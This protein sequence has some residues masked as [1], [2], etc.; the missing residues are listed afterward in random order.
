MVSVSDYAKIPAIVQPRVSPDTGRVAYFSDQSG[1]HE[2]YITTISGETTRLT[3][4][5]PPQNPFSPLIWHPNG[6]RIYLPVGGEDGNKDTVNVGVASLDGSVQTLFTVPRRTILW[7]VAPNGRFLWYFRE[8]DDEEDFNLIR[9]D[10]E[11]GS[12]EE[13]Q[14]NRFVHRGGGVAPTGDRIAFND[15][16]RDEPYGEVFLAASDG[17]DRHPLHINGGDRAFVLGWGPDGNRLLVSS[18]FDDGDLGIHDLREETTEWIRG[19]EGRT[20]GATFLPDGDCVF[21]IRGGEAFVYDCENGEW[22]NLDVNGSVR[23]PPTIQ[24]GSLF[25]SEGVL[26]IRSN[27]TSPGELLRYD[28]R[29]NEITTLVDT[30][31]DELSRSDMEP[32][33]ERTYQ[34]D[35]GEDARVLLY[36]PEMA[37]PAPAVAIVYGGTQQ[38][39][40]RFDALTQL[41]VAE[42]YVVCKPAMTASPYSERE[43]ADFAAAGRWLAEQES[44]DSD[45]I[46]VYGHSHG[47]YNAYSQAVCYS[48]VWNAAIA[49]N[50]MTDLVALADEDDAQWNLRDNM[51]DS[52]DSVETWRNLSPINDADALSIPLLI[53]HGTNDPIV[54]VS[55]ARRFRTA[56]D[57]AGKENYEYHELTGGHGGG[58]DAQQKTEAY[59]QIVEFLH[60][61]L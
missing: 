25:G 33:T 22:R 42:G 34:A 3:D 47:G 19:S 27:E 10:Q 40:R 11:T 38:I 31:P 14:L 21:A 26:L 61:H 18:D 46:A 1:R 9:F 41:L 30:L 53:L 13:I 5:E 4:G 45:R 2:L 59:E 56:L 54:P 57:E 50:G 15:N 35:D 51:P 52:D 16:P 58:T 44:V 32:A 23:L 36:E 24:G 37:E 39:S 29:N 43:H 49:Y 12:H 17:T 60:Y 55:Q 20:W 8:V 6:D 7:D 48:N 28:L